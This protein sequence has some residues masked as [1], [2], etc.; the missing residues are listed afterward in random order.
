MTKLLQTFMDG[1]SVGSLYAL[2]ALGYTMVYGVLQFINFAHGDVVMVGAW[3][4]F[5]IVSVFG[6]AALTGGSIFAA[7]V[8]LVLAMAACGLIGF[9]IERFAYRPLR[10]APRLNVLIT[11]IG[12]SLLIQNVGQLRFVF[13]TEPQPMPQL[14]SNAVLFTVAGVE[15][16][17]LSLIIIAVTVALMVGLDVLVYRSK[18]GLGM[19]AVSH[20]FRTAALMG[21]NVD[22]VISM[23]FVI[24]SSLAA[25][26]GLL[27]AVRYST[28][29]QPADMSW[30]LLGLKAF[31]A[32]VVGGIGNVRG[33]MLGGVLIGMLEQFAR[34]YQNPALADVY[35]FAL[36]IVVLLVKPTGLLGR[37][38]LQK[39]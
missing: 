39:V 29:Q 27:F 1:V 17:A 21:I 10:G 15:F 28:I 9:L 16:R 38:T 5:I 20:D 37:P 36:L 6:W 7:V 13:G 22:R 12:V 31:I 14:V 11:A 33:A 3:L 8:V 18:M 32:A 4:S 34:S 2:V 25:A 35:V 26:G 30:V 24:G 19:R 23:T